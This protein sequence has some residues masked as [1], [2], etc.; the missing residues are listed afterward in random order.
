MH[1]ELEIRRNDTGEKTGEF[2]VTIKIPTLYNTAETRETRF[3]Y[4][5]NDEYQT[6]VDAF[7]AAYTYHRGA[8]DMFN[9]IA[10][11]GL[12]TAIL[13]Q[14]ERKKALDIDKKDGRRTTA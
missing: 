6:A 11:G 8:Q 14:S 10:K 4:G 1:A 5:Q 7:E 12:D 9:S 2:V 3:P 13:A